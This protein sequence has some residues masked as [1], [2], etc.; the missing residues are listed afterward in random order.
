M[1]WRRRWSVRPLRRAKLPPGYRRL[2]KDLARDL[3]AE[4]DRIVL[5][6]RADVARIAKEFNRSEAWVR[7]QLFGGSK[8]ARFLRAV[9][10]TRLYDAY[11]HFRAKELNA[12]RPEGEKL[13]LPEIKETISRE[14]RN[15][16]NRPAEEQARWMAEYEAHKESQAR[17]KRI[18]RKGEQ[19]DAA[20]SLKRASVELETLATRTGVRALL[21]AVRSDILF[22][23]G[24]YVFCDDSVEKFLGVALGK[25]PDQIARA[26]EMWSIHGPSGLA[27][28]PSNAAELKNEVSSLVQ[29]KLDDIAAQRYPVNTP[30]IKMNYKSYESA[31]VARHGVQLRGWD[32]PMK[33]PGTLNMDDVRKVYNGLIN[34]NIYWEVVP[35]PADGE[36][37][38]VVTG[39]KRKTRCDSN[40]P[41]GPNIRTT[42][43]A[44]NGSGASTS[45]HVKKRRK[46]GN[47]GTES[48]EEEEEEDDSDG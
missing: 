38:G 26:M 35:P 36:D 46:R 17:D 42:G 1:G 4:L 30:N 31:I 9:R 13:K 34:Q 8:S 22:T 41:R 20:S 45:K 5:A 16:K 33:A 7:S 12:D 19:L 24:P 27:A 29:A 21:I 11:V 39:R 43:R 28:A 37:P 48:E 23:M 14:R 15:Y 3:H 44:A 18:N 2:K 47:D 32:V 25:T 6:L 40:V 10:K